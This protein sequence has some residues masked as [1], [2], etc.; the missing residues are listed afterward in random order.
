MTSGWRFTRFGLFGSRLSR[1][2]ACYAELWPRQSRFARLL[3]APATQKR[4][5]KSKSL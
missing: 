2:T 5:E 1:F 4:H 3:A